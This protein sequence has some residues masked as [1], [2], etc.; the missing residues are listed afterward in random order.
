MSTLMVEAQHYISHVYIAA[1]VHYHFCSIM[2]ERMQ[3]K[4]SK[5]YKESR[6]K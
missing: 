2:L 6:N 5:L 3:K 4:D 1:E